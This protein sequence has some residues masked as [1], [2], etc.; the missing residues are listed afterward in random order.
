MNEYEY[1]LF[2]KWKEQSLTESEKIE[3]KKLLIY[4]EWKKMTE[5]VRYILKKILAKEQDKG[6]VHVFCTKERCYVKVDRD[7]FNI[8]LE[9]LNKMNLDEVKE[10]LL[11]E[12]WY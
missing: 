10:W 9:R 1:D 5:R 11:K 12:L 3:Y 6:K 2:I 4:F 7:S 8:P